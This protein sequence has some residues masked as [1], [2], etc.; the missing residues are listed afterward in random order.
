MS[1]LS[2]LKN[3]QKTPQTLADFQTVRRTQLIYSRLAS[4]FGTYGIA[5][6]ITGQAQI[7]IIAILV[8]Y[9]TAFLPFFSVQI[10]GIVDA[11]RQVAWMKLIFFAGL[12]MYFGYALFM[13][14]TGQVRHYQSGFTWGVTASGLLLFFAYKMKNG[15]HARAIESIIADMKGGE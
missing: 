8:L 13:L 7:Q 5:I 9:I 12:V 15:R 4:I 2:S 10:V 6:S 3:E 11:V 1:I 14:A